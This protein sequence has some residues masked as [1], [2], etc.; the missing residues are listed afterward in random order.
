MSGHIR[1]KG[2]SHICMYFLNEWVLN[3]C[4]LVVGPHAFTPPLASGSFDVCHS[5]RLWVG[6]LAAKLD[7]K[8]VGSAPSPN[9]PSTTRK[10]LGGWLQ[11]TS[12]P[13]KEERTA[14]GQRNHLRSESLPERRRS[15]PLFDASLE[16]AVSQ[17]C[18]STASSAEN[19]VTPTTSSYKSYRSV[20]DDRSA[21]AM[22]L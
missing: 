7:A 2:P 14:W 1:P 21:T 9:H 8:G 6:R 12:L 19:D 17:N 22:S 16:N 18:F 11:S 10:E 3:Q 13:Q 15:P 20:L 4:R 5:L